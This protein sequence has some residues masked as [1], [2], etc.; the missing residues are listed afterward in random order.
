MKWNLGVRAYPRFQVC[1]EEDG[2]VNANEEAVCFI[3]LKKGFNSHTHTVSPKKAP[4]N[5]NENEN[6]KNV[7]TS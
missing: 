4:K 3:A 1:R 6:E 2:D 5:E 7:G